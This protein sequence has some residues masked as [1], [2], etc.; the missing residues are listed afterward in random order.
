MEIV[1]LRAQLADAHATITE[2]RNKL[3]LRP[4]AEESLKTPEEVLCQ[5]EIEKLRQLAE[6]RPLS[7][8]ET[9][10]LEVYIKMLYLIRSSAPKTFDGSIKD[11][12]SIEEAELL[13]L[14]KL[15]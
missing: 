10:Q 11:L 3:A 12:A 1:E 5:V 14:A 8:P 9:K 2:L 15:D 4:A 13:N 6:H 7:P